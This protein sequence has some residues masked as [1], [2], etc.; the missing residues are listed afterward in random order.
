[1]LITYTLQHLAVDGI[2]GAALAA[3]AVREEFLEPIIFYF[4]LYNLLAFGLQAAAG[5]FLDKH[6]K[7]LRAA[8]VVSLVALGLGIFSAPEIF[9]QVIFLGVGNC[10]FHVTAGSIV[11]RSFKTY[12]ELGLFVSSGAIGLALGLNQLV[13]AKIFLVIYFALTCYI[14]TNFKPENLPSPEIF[15]GQKNSGKSFFAAVSCAILLLSCV[16][17]RGFGGGGTSAEFVMLFPIIFA[18]GKI[19]GGVCCDKLGWQNTILLIFVAGFSSLQFEGLVPLAVLTLTFNMTMP[20]T[21]RLL[22]FCNPRCPGLM[23]GLA[24]GCLLPGAFFKENFTVA[25]QAMVVIQFLILFVAW[26]IFSRK[27]LAVEA[28]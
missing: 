19:L 24:A 12:K 4:A 14:L 20:L 3:Y 6:E 17:M 10:L 28:A 9:A 23:F 1:M 26:K 25:V 13:D 21:L 11:L 2:C 27:N 16:I 5:F 8:F 7:F 22:H 18:A 15:S